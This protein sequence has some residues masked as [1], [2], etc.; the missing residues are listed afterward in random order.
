MA[1]SSVAEPDAD[2]MVQFGGLV[3]DRETDDIE[4]ATV[5]GA[6]VQRHGMATSSAHQHEFN[7]NSQSLVL[8]FADSL[9]TRT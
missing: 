3:G 1:P 2:S 5:H 7:V 4:R 9:R 8:F 6:T